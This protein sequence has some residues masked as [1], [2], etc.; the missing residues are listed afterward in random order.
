MEVIINSY[1]K[2]TTFDHIKVGQVFK[3][4]GNYYLRTSK[5][6]FNYEEGKCNWNA[7]NLKEKDVAGL[8]DWATVIPLKATL[9]I[10]EK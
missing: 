3:H 1:C 7:F 8:E 10:E 2:E 9:T 6:P 4:E 5:F